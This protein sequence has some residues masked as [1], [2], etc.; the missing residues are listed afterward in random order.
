M[1]TTTTTAELAESTIDVFVCHRT[2]VL[3]PFFATTTRSL[4]CLDRKA[5][6]RCVFNSF[7]AVPLSVMSQSRVRSSCLGCF[8]GRGL[9]WAASSLEHL[10]NSRFHVDD[11]AY[12]YTLV[13]TLRGIQLSHC[14]I[15]S[16]SKSNRN[17]TCTCTDI[18]R[19]KERRAPRPR[20]GSLAVRLD[21]AFIIAMD[22]TC[23]IPK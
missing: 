3:F 19:Q 6:L 8:L 2:A 10:R 1:T 4:N 20:I 16:R 12:F 18:V 9:F 21:P 14:I 23:R 5:A 13:T 11:D 22:N 15:T 17:F 7:S